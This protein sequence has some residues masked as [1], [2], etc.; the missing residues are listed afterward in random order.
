MVRLRAE[1]FDDLDTLDGIRAALQ[2]AVRLEHATIPTYL[3]ALFSLKPGANDEIGQ[4]ISSVVAEEMAH[5]ALAANLLNAIGGSPI[6]DDPSVLPAYPG[7]LPGGVDADLTVHLEPFSLDL[8]RGTFMVIEHP[9]HPLDFPTAAAAQPPEETIGQ[10]YARIARTIAKLGDSIF[11][12]DPSRQMAHGFAAVEVIPV[13]DVASAQAAIRIIVEQGEGT[14][15]SPLDPEGGRGALAH[16]YR[17]AEIANGH[18][19]VPNPHAD[20][21]TPP[22]RR[23][24]YDGPAIPF[25]PAGVIPLVTDPKAADYA[26]GSSARHLCDTFNYTYT[27]LLKALHAAF[28]GA[29]GTLPAAIGLMFSLKEQFMEMTSADAPHSAAVPAPSFEYQPLLP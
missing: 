17:F 18:Q 9:E 3:Y 15:Q 8:V 2:N 27:T 24:A 14:T 12:G 4:L 19:L 13:S 23:F 28:N 10:F 25:D 26:A 29:P 5:M 1:L 11:T 7:P 16:Y 20:P 21:R 22:D 6:V